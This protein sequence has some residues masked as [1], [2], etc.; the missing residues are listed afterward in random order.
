MKAY[1][2]AK[3]EPNQ[4]P[5][6]AVRSRQSRYDKRAG[7][8]LRRRAAHKHPMEQLQA[9]VDELL[10]LSGRVRKRSS[11][12]LI[13]GP[14]W[15]WKDRWLQLIE[16]P[17]GR[18]KVGKPQLFGKPQMRPRP[19]LALEYRHHSNS[20]RVLGELPLAGISGGGYRLI[21]KS[22]PNG[23]RTLDLHA[24]HIPRDS[25]A[26]SAFP[27]VVVC[28]QRDSRTLVRGDPTLFMAAS[29]SHEVCTDNVWAARAL[30]R[31]V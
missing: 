7:F 1:S 24:A 29:S 27:G 28:G 22:G 12:A 15:V 30:M 9:A 17:Q 2:A 21:L 13:G 16:M 8:A 20:K 26:Y 19:A 6:K 5:L 31:P 14:E 18:Q 3:L 4:T 23:D 11:D 25:V 10:Q